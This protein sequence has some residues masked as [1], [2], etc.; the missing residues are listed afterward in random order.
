L[1]SDEILQQTRKRYKYLSHL[2]IS[3]GFKFCLIELDSKSLPTPKNLEGFRQDLL[4]RNARL[5]Y[6]SDQQEKILA[7]SR[8]AAQA[9]AEAQ[10]ASRLALHFSDLKP[11]SDEPLDLASSEA[12]PAVLGAGAASPTTDPSPAPAKLQAWSEPLGAT[13]WAAQ[14][15]GVKEE[16]PTLASTTGPTPAPTPSRPATQAPAGVWGNPESKQAPKFP[17]AVQNPPAQQPKKAKKQKLVLVSHNLFK[18]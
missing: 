4:R 11:F 2:P 14:P 5:K 15:R 13:V 7:R 3:C 18:L 10:G 6:E 9:E 16:F 1:V 8:A 12:F 17:V